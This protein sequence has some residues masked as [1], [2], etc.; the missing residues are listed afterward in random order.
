MI[1]PSER[2]SAPVIPAR[3]GIERMDFCNPPL[4]NRR[5][6][7][8]DCATTQFGEGAR[9]VNGQGMYLE[10]R[11]QPQEGD[12]AQAR[13]PI[14]IDALIAGGESETV[15]F[16]PTLR[17]DLRTGKNEKYIVQ[18]SL[19][20]VAAFQNSRVGGTLII[21]VADDGEPVGIGKDNFQNEDRMA[22]YFTNIV[23]RGMGAV[24]ATRVRL[25]FI[26][27]RKSVVLAVRCDPS[28]QP[29]YVNDGNNIRFYVRTGLATTE[30]SVR[31][32]VEY[33]NE[34]FPRRG[35]A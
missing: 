3:T 32:A 14:D 15:E 31:D 8:Y 1:A 29:V 22:L 21:G 10:T 33:I 2:N 30:L 18:A 6:A 17:V 16:K 25:D 13:E 11:G 19:K 9:N 20:T 5:A 23:T 28:T 12:N 27:Y 35:G 34:N 4:A 24:A 7:V 26:K